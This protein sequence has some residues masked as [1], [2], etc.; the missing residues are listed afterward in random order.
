LLLGGDTG[1][2]HLAHALGVPVLALHG[3]TDPQRHGPYGAPERALYQ[4]LPCSFC[5]RRF[6]ETKACLL[7]IAPGDVVARSLAAL[8]AG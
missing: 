6:T 8:A 4:R 2:L 3:P 1:P 5:Y 7:E